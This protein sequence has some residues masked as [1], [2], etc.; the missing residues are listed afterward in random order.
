MSIL[1]FGSILEFAPLHHERQAV[2]CRHY[3]LKAHPLLPRKNSIILAAMMN[4]LCFQCLTLR[5]LVLLLRKLVLAS[6][7]LC[8]TH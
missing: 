6:L 5:P 7:L 8:Y 2:Y 4:V 1:Y 3:K